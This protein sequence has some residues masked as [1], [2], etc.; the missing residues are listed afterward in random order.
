MNIQN[1]APCQCAIPSLNISPEWIG[2]GITRSRVRKGG[3]DE[4]EEWENKGEGG[5]VKHLRWERARG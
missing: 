3:G 1:Y 4:E 2:K 5:A